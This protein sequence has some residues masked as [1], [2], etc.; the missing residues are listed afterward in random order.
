MTHE[1]KCWPEFFAAVRRWEKMFEIRHNDRNFKV[2]DV[3]YLREWHPGAEAYTGSF[4]VRRI[5]YVTDF[6]HGLKDGYV[7]MGIVDVTEKCSD[8]PPVGYP[9]DKT[10]CDSCPLRSG[11]KNGTVSATQTYA[12]RDEKGGTK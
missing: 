11:P 9:T 6:P 3:L 4:V 1:L 12:G 5:T 10:R 2:G 8:C 7:C